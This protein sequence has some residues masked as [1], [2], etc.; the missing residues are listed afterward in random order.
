MT[1]IR[2]PFSLRSAAAGLAVVAL[3]SV[4]ACSSEEP[5]TSTA[6]STSATAETSAAETTATE[7]TAAETTSAETTATETDGEF[8]DESLAAILSQVTIDGATVT[9]MPISLVRT[10]GAAAE[11]TVEPAACSFAGE[12]LLP[13]INDNPAALAAPSATTG[14][15]LVALSAADADKLIAD[16]NALLDNPECANVTLTTEGQ[17][18]QSTIKSEDSDGFGMDSPRIMVSNS[19]TGDLYGFTARKG[20]VIVSVNSPD[21]A[22]IEAVA[23]QIAANL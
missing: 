16:R 11:I 13:Y 1:R 21:K 3:L 10:G 9:P 12:G 4:A 20:N 15:S 18:I 23:T 5:T 6:P 17:T 2:N 8:T 14:M 22:Q 7:T 19:G